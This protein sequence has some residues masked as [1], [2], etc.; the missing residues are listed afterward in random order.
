MARLVVG[1]IKGKLVA[2]RIAPWNERSSS[3]GV[4]FKGFCD[5][6]KV[7]IMQK[8]ISQIW[9]HTWNESKIV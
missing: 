3:R 5:V 9:L 4:F 8:I 1:Q 6:A 2:A 7:T